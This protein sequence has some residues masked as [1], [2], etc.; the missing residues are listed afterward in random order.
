MPATQSLDFAAQFK[1]AAYFFVVQHTEA[2]D[3]GS[4][5]SD[6]FY[7]FVGVQIEVLL[8]PNGK[9]HRIGKFEG[10][11]QIRLDPG[12]AQLVL[13]AEKSLHGMIR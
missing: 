4:R 8:M 10:F 12:F 2:I 6:H 11:G 1:I 7:H 3:H 5:A 13:I 9:N